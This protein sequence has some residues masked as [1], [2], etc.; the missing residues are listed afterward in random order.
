MKAPHFR[1]TKY[2]ELI[3]STWKCCW[4]MNKIVMTKQCFCSSE[5]KKKA[6]L[7]CLVFTLAKE[8][9]FLKISKSCLH[10]TWSTC[11]LLLRW[12]SHWLHCHDVCGHPASRCAVAHHCNSNALLSLSVRI[13]QKRKISSSLTGTI[14][15]TSHLF[16]VKFELD[17]PEKAP[18]KGPAYTLS[19][20]QW[21]SFTCTWL[22]F[23]YSRLANRCANMPY[24]INEF[25]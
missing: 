12:Y 25:Q 7:C 18:E 24:G 3:W 10:L 9:S 23:A 2:I 21:N 20:L 15:K 13:N 22:L 4:S 1:S 17:I 16:I 8:Q 6:A 14:W 19:I 5:I 11:Y